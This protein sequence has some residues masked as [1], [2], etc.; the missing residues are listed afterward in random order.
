[1]PLMALSPSGTEVTLQAQTPLLPNTLYHFSA[2]CGYQDQ[3]GNSGAGLTGYFY[4]GN[5]AVSTGP[6]VTVS[7]LPGATAIPLNAQVL[8]S[9]S[10]LI[11]PTSWSQSSIQLLDQANDPV[12][13]VVSLSNSQT[14]TFVPTSPLVPGVTYTVNVNGFDDTNGNPVVPSS[15]TFTTGSVASPGGF[16]LTSTNITSGAT[17]V[18]ATQQIIL[19]FSQILDPT[20]VNA[21]S[22]PVSVNTPY[23]SAL[24]GT[25]AVNGNTVT[26]TP[27]SPYPAGALI[28][29]YSNSGIT[30]VLGDALPGQQ[31]DY[32]YVTTATPDTTP[33]QV[34]S[35]NPPNGATN[36]RHD[37]PVSVTFNKSINPGSTSGYNTQ[38]FAG[39]DLQ[40]NGSVTLSADNRTLVFNNG[41]LSNATI[42]TIALPAGGITDM[43]GNGL[44]NNFISSFTSA[45]NPAA[46]TGS[47]QSVSP[48]WN[49][50]GIPTDT[51]LT[52]YVTSPVN[53]ATLPGNLTVTVNGKVDAGTVQSAASGL[54]VQFTPSAPFPSG[55]VVQWFLSASVMDVYG[56]AFAAN[57]G[58]FY[59]VA[60]I[61]PATA[62]PQIVAISPASNTSSMPT[63][64][65]IDIEF[66]LPVDPTTLSGNV[67]LV[68]PSAGGD[69]PVTI[70]QPSP[71]IVRLTPSPLLNPASPYYLCASNG[72][73]LGTN[74]V[75]A[76][77][78]CYWADYI[79][80]ASGPDTT[81]GTVK[82]GPPN[83]SVNVG[84]NAFIRFQFSK[85][86][87]I[88][89]INAA[90]VQV[91][92]GGN[93]IPGTWTY[94]YSGYDVLGAN[95]YPV[96][97]LPAS[98]TIQISVSGLLDYAGNTFAAAN[99]QFTTAAL[100]DFT[101][102]KCRV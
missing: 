55:A 37:I 2:C 57:T 41:A 76:Q 82:I 62:S 60:A 20:T 23:S 71:N 10:A 61:N 88:T 58:Y 74:G 32:F 4:T 8:V 80:T 72:S 42:Y 96:N 5:G 17:N 49:A 87:D 18:S 25:Y 21:A 89:T 1:M 75:A 19:T 101:N 84:T 39:Q 94:N 22:L 73:V 56:N 40:V 3:D 38:L 15:S 26:F 100:P 46:G 13:G 79:T 34:I 90:T 16:T 28:Y 98:S 36:V 14:L 35:V 68:D 47:V 11:D 86:V 102:A 45:T 30:D 85:P 6:T 7:P 50:S 27:L 43:S 33:L 65:E 59:T 29:V 52:L 53:A 31:L 69:F 97:P 83:G 67:F 54:E 24:A 12:A 81:P 51:L 66:S 77:T 48:T 70:T 99:S 9:V 93:A 78:D 63:N 91:T 92:S 64:G 95:F 44:A